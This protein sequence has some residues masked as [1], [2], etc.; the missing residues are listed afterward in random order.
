ME[1]K[2]RKKSELGWRYRYY[3]AARRCRVSAEE[4]RGHHPG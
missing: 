2:G 1:A 3:G 4:R